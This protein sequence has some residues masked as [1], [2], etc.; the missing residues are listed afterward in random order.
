MFERC[1]TSS[2]GFVETVIEGERTIEVV[3]RVIECELEIFGER[4]SMTLSPIA[5]FRKRVEAW[6]SLSSYESM[7]LKIFTIDLTF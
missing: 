4:G 2:E 6:N 3:V 1:E 5:V 7:M